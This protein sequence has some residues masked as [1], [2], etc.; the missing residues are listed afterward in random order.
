M[1]GRANSAVKR[2]GAIWVTDVVVEEL[3]LNIEIRIRNFEKLGM[4][5]FFQVH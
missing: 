4:V 2:H 1:D 3:S 5:G